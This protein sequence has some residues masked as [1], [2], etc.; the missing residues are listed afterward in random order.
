MLAMR[1]KSEIWLALAVTALACAGAGG[2]FHYVWRYGVNLPIVDGWYLGQTLLGWREHGIRWQE[3]FA[4]HNEHRLAVPRLLFA[5]LAAVTG[6]NVKAEMFLSVTL[7]MATLAML[8]WAWWKFRPSGP[9]A[10]WVSGGALMAALLPALGQWQNWL[11]GFQVPWFLLPC[12][13]VAGLLAATAQRPPWVRFTVVLLLMAAAT[14]SMANGLV[15]WI[16]VA[17]ALLVPVWAR[18][19]SSRVSLSLAYLA[20]FALLTAAYLLGYQKPPTHAGIGAALHMPLALARFFGAVVG[21][22]V[23]AELAGPYGKPHV[24]AGWVVV[25]GWGLMLAWLT[26]AGVGIR[27]RAWDSPGF[28]IG[29]GCGMFGLGSAAAISLGRVAMGADFAF[30]SRY[31]TFAQYAWVGAAF[32]LPMVQGGARWRWSVATGCAVCLGLVLLVNLSATRRGMDMRLAHGRLKAVLQLAKTLPQR[33]EMLTL[34]QG[35]PLDTWRDL[36]RKLDRA[37]LVQPRLTRPENM[38]AS[39]VEPTAGAPAP[40][41][42]DAVRVTPAGLEINGWARLR[43]LEMPADAVVAARVLADGR[44]ELLAISQADRGDRPDVTHAYRQ[45]GLFKSGWMLRLPQGHEAD[46]LILLGFDAERGRF[47]L[48]GR[49]EQGR[50]V[51]SAPVS[52]SR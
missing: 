35:F 30:E 37:G 50:P 26:L 13:L 4:F 36:V 23:A 18:R 1:H 3:V 5:A 21:A 10:A 16:A 15:L 27:R 7:A 48:L 49:V 25:L 29:V 31:T 32:L 41:S 24:S 11:W 34:A 43:R 12:L 33:D 20:M 6:W 39:I 46:T 47:H 19:E 40:G 14:F 38:A 9:T 22:P 44:H 17:P 52:L 45:P 28:L 8:L 2:L 51:R 42:V